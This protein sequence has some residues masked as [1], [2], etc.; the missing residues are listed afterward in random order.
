[1]K[2]FFKGLFCKHKNYEFYA[3]SISGDKTVMCLCKDC[4]DA[5]IKDIKSCILKGWEVD[6]KLQQTRPNIKK[7]YDIEW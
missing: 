1:M 5:F 2:N 7:I 4:G 6:G 3:A